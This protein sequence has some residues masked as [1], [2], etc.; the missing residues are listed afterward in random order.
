MEMKGKGGQTPETRSGRML[1]AVRQPMYYR[2]KAGDLIT[3]PAGMT[4]D[5]ASIPAIVSP[6]LHPDGP[7]ARAA[8]VHDLCY[9]S[10]GSMMWK[11]HPGRS[12]PAPYTRA[13]CDDILDEAMAALGVPWPQRWA[14]WS[15]VRAG[16]SA[17]FGH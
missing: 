1:W 17:A 4:T 14:I 3:V 5:L 9:A 8:V 15:G 6:L 16:G 12:R 11:G 2:T 10:R 13:E 7:W